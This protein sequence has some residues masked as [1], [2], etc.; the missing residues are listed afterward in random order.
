MNK[1]TR[2]QIED[3][4]SQLEE[5]RG[6]LGDLKDEVANIQSEEQEKFDN[7]PEGLQQG[8]G[9]QAIEAAANSLSECESEFDNMDSEFETVINALNTAAE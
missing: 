2:K 1:A 3:I 5:L 6:K 4:V 9:G 8:D 7:M